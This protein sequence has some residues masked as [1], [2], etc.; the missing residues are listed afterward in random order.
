MR[1]SDGYKTRQVRRIALQGR[2]VHDLDAR[3]APQQLT[4][5]VGGEG[6]LRLDRQRLGVAAQD[7]NAHAGAADA[8]LR[9]VKDL[10]RFVAHL[11]LQPFLKLKNLILQK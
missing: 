1:Q 6:A 10:T 3:R 5:L 7:G 4:D 2:L 8:Q 9:R 11:Q